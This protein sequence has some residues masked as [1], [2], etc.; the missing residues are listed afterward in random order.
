MITVSVRTKYC[1]PSDCHTSLPVTELAGGCS[2]LRNAALVPPPVALVPDEGHAAVH[3]G[4]SCYSMLYYWLQPTPRARHAGF[5]LRR[6]GESLFLH[7]LAVLSCSQW[8]CSAS[9]CSSRT[10]CAGT[11]FLR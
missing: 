5:S 2:A 11:C 4:G 9:S 8:Y 3:A 6:D 1:Y 10:R 7:T